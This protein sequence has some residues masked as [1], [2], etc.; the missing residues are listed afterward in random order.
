MFV[1]KDKGCNCTRTECDDSDLNWEKNP[2]FY[3]TAVAQYGGGR[4]PSVSVE[5]HLLNVNDNAPQLRYSYYE[6][7]IKENSA[8]F[9]S[10]K[11]QIFVQVSGI[12]DI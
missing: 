9:S 3:L 10:G 6:T 8:T 1:A 7:S 12:C 4:R 5:I 11:Q 2:V